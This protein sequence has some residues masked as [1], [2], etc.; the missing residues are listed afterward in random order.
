MIYNIKKIG[1]IE[2]IREI[3]SGGMGV[4]Y[5]G[6]DSLLERKVAVKMMLPNVITPQGRKRFLKEAAVMAKITHPSI[7]NI[8]SFGEIDVDGLRVPYFVMEYVEGRSLADVILRLKL[9]KENN[10][11]ELEEYG[12]IKH[13]SNVFS[14]NYFLK[15][16]VNVP[17]KEKEWIENSANL[18]SSIA[19][20]LY[21]VHREGII[22]RD[23]KPSNILISKKGPKIADF[24]LVKNLMSNSISTQTDFVGTIKYSAPE[25]F[26]KGKYTVQ[27]DIFSLGIVFYEILTLTH[28]FEE[29]L[30]ESPA[31]FMNKILSSEIKPVHIVNNAVPESVSNVV[32]KM[33]AKD[34]KKRYLTMKEVS[35][36]IML[37]RKSNI[38]KIIMDI[39]TVF[40]PDEEFSVSKTDEEL[41]NMKLESAIKSYITIDFAEAIYFINDAIHFNQLN[42]DAYLLAILISLHYGDF[43]KKIKERF[44]EVKDYVLRSNEDKTREKA[45][46]IDC[47]FRKDWKWIDYAI[48]YS[49][50]YK[51]FIL[52]HIISRKR[53]DLAEVFLKKALEE[54]PQY[55]DFSKLMMD[56]FSKNLNFSEIKK[57]KEKENIDIIVRM[58]LMEQYL[59]FDYDIKAFEKEVIEAEK[60]YPYHSSILIH[61]MY[62]DIIKSDWDSF[63]ID[64]NKIISVHPD[65]IKSNYYY[66]LYLFY[67][68]KGSAENAEKYLKIVQNLSDNKMKKIEEFQEDLKNIN[69]S[70]FDSSTRKIGELSYRIFLKDFIDNL[71]E[72]NCM[73]FFKVNTKTVFI[74]DEVYFIYISSRASGQIDF[75][76]LGNFYDIKGNILK[77][78]YRSKDSN[79]YIVDIEQ[80][81][82]IKDMPVIFSGTQNNLLKTDGK[83]CILDYREVILVPRVSKRI[84]VLSD[85]YTVKNIESSVGYR[86]ED[87]GGYRIIIVDINTIHDY[88]K[89][90]LNIKIEAEKIK[91]F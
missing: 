54:F 20:A 76:P 15:E 71:L 78:K 37:S 28:P 73:W 65:D 3:G 79:S 1:N 68:R 17:I 40:K 58:L 30:D 29:F 55:S 19:D 59:W 38:G 72:T 35:E 45:V 27:S 22:H 63:L 67:H 43:L 18:I 47:Y 46:I 77:V 21:E 4:V 80:N 82:D 10:P 49:K 53:K 85:R 16:F 75:I 91:D 44:E 9:L 33:L 50:K 86:I 12:Y 70:V 41:S 69:P 60:K 11:R 90:E 48:N 8:Y 23:I 57:M 24:G 83:N 42:L 66:F 89:F 51:N 88:K 74:D 39:K 25:V 64:V 52:Y 56:I 32:I 7:I 87:I 34:P 36:S 2:I 26:S 6:F 61:K 81:D 5:E 62:L 13:V 14:G 31:Y 84:F